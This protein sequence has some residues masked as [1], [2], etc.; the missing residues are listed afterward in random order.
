MNLA[1]T[2][3]EIDPCQAQGVSDQKNPLL[4]MRS[5]IS[6]QVSKIDCITNIMIANLPKSDLKKKNYDKI[7]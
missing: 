2:R 3:R 5:S 6:K 4:L 7:F 1:S